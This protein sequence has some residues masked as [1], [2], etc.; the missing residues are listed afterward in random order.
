MKNIAFLQALE[1]YEVKDYAGASFDFTR[2]LEVEPEQAEIYY[3][4]AMC[5][6]H[7]H[8]NNLALLDADYA[9]KADPNNGFRYACRA[10]MRDVFGDTQGAIED[11]SSAIRLDPD[12]L[13]SHNNLGILADKMGQKTISKGHYDKADSLL[14]VASNSGINKM[15]GTFNPADQ[16]RSKGT[17]IPE[18]I[19]MSYWS[20]A[21]QTL[22]SISGIK[23]LLRFIGNGFKMSSRHSISEEHS[24]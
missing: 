14:G 10:Y 16:V 5:Y 1:K 15:M 19:H 11:Y 24:D 18:P 12:D 3:Q 20:I 22:S 8:K 9:L 4:R 21:V 17:K 13:I 23:A 2:A 7:L 6:F